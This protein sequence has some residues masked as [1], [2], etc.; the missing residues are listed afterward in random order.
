LVLF[1][2]LVLG[3]GIKPRGFGRRKPVNGSRQKGLSSKRSDPLTQPVIIKEELPA[4]RLPG[5]MNPLH[6][7][8]RSTPHK[9]HAYLTCLSEVDRQKMVAPLPVSTEDL[10]FGKDPQQCTIVLDEASVDAIHACLKREGHSYRILDLGSIA[11]TWVNYTP[12]SGE[13]TLLEHGD[14]VHIGR[15]GF[16]FTLR[17]PAKPVKP[18]IT[19]QEPVE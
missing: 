8:H 11:G 17:T 6:W 19:P 16:R 15:M 18:V 9:A 4:R 13:G 10:S 12:V 7:P 3:G 14:L 5:W 2:V 1:L